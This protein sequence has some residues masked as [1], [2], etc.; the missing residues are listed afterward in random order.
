VPL[1]SGTGNQEHRPAENYGEA[2]VKRPPG[3]ARASVTYSRPIG[4]ADV[5]GNR[6]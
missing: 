4:I 3:A 2:N 6:C 1:G 5:V